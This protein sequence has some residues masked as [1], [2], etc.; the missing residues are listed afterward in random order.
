[1]LRRLR[2]QPRSDASQRPNQAMHIPT[3]LR[4][5]AIAI[6]LCPAITVF[7][8][9][10]PDPSQ[11]KEKP[12]VRPDESK[13]VQKDGSV[14]MPKVD[15]DYTAG[16]ARLSPDGTI[17][18]PAAPDVPSKAPPAVKSSNTSPSPAPSG[19]KAR[20][21]SQRAKDVFPKINEPAAKPRPTATISVRP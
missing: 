8:E 6:L 14:H 10:P 5:S 21:P 12:I 9:P 2:P 7:C 17:K 20:D 13:K 1:M 16:K 15:I 4:T 11:L 3:A 18:E 19:G